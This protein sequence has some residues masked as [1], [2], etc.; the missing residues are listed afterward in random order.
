M[1][2]EKVG[3]L[4]FLGRL[5]ASGGLEFRLLDDNRKIYFVNEEKEEELLKKLK[6]GMVIECTLIRTYNKEFDYEIILEFDPNEIFNFS[7]KPNKIKKDERIMNEKELI[8]KKQ[9]LLEVSRSKKEQLEYFILRLPTM[10]KDITKETDDL[11]NKINSKRIEIIKF[12]D[13]YFNDKVE[14]RIIKE[15]VAIERR[16]E[17]TN[18]ME[19]EEGEIFKVDKKKHFQKK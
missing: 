7:N 8:E 9:E 14:T 12:T 17:K 10:F 1:S 2:K 15:I 19:K 18:K 5:S 16:M 6:I 4:E 3:K 11:L 13:D